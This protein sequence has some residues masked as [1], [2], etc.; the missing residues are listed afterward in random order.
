MLAQA[1]SSTSITPWLRKRIKRIADSNP[2]LRD[3]LDMLLKRAVDDE[4]MALVRA[5]R[6]DSACCAVGC[7]DAIGDAAG[8]RAQD[9]IADRKIGGCL[10]SAAVQLR[11][12]TT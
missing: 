12:Q 1:S 9:E 5:R 3:E 8:H 7:G 4:L 10:K 11:V 6:I 2:Y